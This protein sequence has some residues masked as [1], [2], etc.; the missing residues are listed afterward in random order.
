MAPFVFLN[1]Y[2]LK[3]TI[4]HKY[5]LYKYVVTNELHVVAQEGIIRLCVKT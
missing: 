3:T 5:I 1:F 4:K 2:L